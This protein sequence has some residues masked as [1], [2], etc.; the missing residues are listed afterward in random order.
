MR[1]DLIIGPMFAGKSSKLIQT[2]K[3]YV[4]MGKKCIIINTVLDTRCDQVVKTHD[5]ST[6]AA[7]KYSKLMDFHG[8]EEYNTCEVIGI[9]E[10][11]FFD[12]LVDFVHLAEADNKTMI[13]AGLNGNIDRKPMGQIPQLIGMVDSIKL[14][15][16]VSASDEN[17]TDALFS[18]RESNMDPNVIIPGGKELYR[19]VTRQEF[20]KIKK[21]TKLTT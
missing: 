11:Q 2:I 1:I 4:I 19:A 5:N 18:V 9:D 3:R 14:L 10:A 12:D 20:L 17:N 6:Y 7:I 13:I 21:I 16:A 15:K 8:T